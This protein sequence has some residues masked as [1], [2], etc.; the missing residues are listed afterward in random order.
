MSRDELRVKHA[1]RQMLMKMLII[2][3]QQIEGHSNPDRLTVV[4]PQAEARTRLPRVNTL[5]FTR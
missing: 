5:D 2:L 4:T 3:R 1:M